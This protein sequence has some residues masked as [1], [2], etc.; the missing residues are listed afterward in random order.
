[1]HAQQ[2]NANTNTTTDLQLQEQHAQA[3]V[4]Q[5]RDASMQ[6]QSLKRVKIDEL[7]KGIHNYYAHLGLDF[8]KAVPLLPGGDHDEKKEQTLR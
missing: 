3:R 2:P 5:T 8:E 7:T 1:M 4:H 6:V